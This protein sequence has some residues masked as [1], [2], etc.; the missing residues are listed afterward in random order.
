MRAIGVEDDDEGQALEVFID[1]GLEK[2]L[3]SADEFKDLQKLHGH[4]GLSKGLK[5]RITN[6]LQKQERKVK[7]QSV[8]VDAVTGYDI[9]EVVSPPYNPNVLVKLLEK[10]STHYAAIK[11]K[12]DNIVGLGYTLVESNVAKRSIE[13]KNAEQTEKFRRKLERIKDDVHVWLDDCNDLDLFIETLKKV[14]MDY[15]TI[16]WGCIEI[17]RTRDGRIGYIG[18][19]PSKTIRIRRQR[20]GFVQVSSNKVKFF[21]NYGDQETANPL[22]SDSGKVNEII[23]LKKYSPSNTYYGVPDIVAAQEA[24]AGNTYASEYNLDYFANKAVPRYLVLVKGAQL[25]SQQQ[26]RIFQF[27]NTKLKG[28]NHRSLIV[29]IPADTDNKK[30]SFEI[31]PI[32]SGLQDS[33]F[34]GY[35]KSN[36]EE[37]LMAHRV[38][39]SKIAMASGINVALAKELSRTFSEEVADPERR[40]LELKLNKILAEYTNALYM[41]LEVSNLVDELT[42]STIDVNNS[43]IG[44]RTPNELRARDGLNGVKEGDKSML[45]IQTKASQA[46][47]R[48]D[49]KANTNKDRERDQRRQESATSNEAEGRDSKGSGARSD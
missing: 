17:G 22:K 20:D 30:V 38:P 26:Q 33:S 27:F 46:Q 8:D 3:D 5:R 36:N 47:Q 4:D 28:Q 18:H 45:E 10:S 25:G 31:K 21:R 16:G 24:L 2:S 14:Y 44:T 7:S 40:I 23:M 49:Q 42:Q 15:E 35:K 9:L 48:A 6:D 37:I 34:G 39:A 41:K 29:P 32:E 13:N 11:A 43:K 12:V 19:I 1:S